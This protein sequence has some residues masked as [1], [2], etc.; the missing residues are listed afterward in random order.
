MGLDGIYLLVSSF[1]PYLDVCLE[2][3]ETGCPDES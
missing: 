3:L 2:T 1:E